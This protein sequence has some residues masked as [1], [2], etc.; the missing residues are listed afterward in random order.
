MYMG[1]EAWSA[2]RLV[3][4]RG[5]RVNAVREVIWKKCLIS[6]SQVEYAL[7]AWIGDYTDF[8]TSIHHAMNVGKL[9]RPDQPLMPNYQWIPIGYHGRSSSIMVSGHDIIRPR[10]QL[11]ALNDIAPKLGASQK[12]D[13]EL[14]LG[15]YIGVGNELGK[16]VAIDD[17]TQHVFGLCVLNDWSAR[18]IQAWEYQPLGPFLSKNFASSVS[19]WIVTIEALQPYM[20]DWQRPADH[21]QPLAYLDSDLHRATG[22][23]NIG[24]DVWLQTESMR[25]LGQWHHVSHSNYAD[26]YWTLAQ[27]VAHH[28]INGCNL[29]TGDLLG[30]GTQSG[31][32]LSQAGALIELTANGQQPLHLLNGEK[33]GFLS[34]GDSVKMTASCEREG[35][36][37]IGFGEVVG[38]ILPAVE[39]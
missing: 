22:A 18:D 16:S 24:L 30:T 7:P 2:L 33:R 13:Y 26:A 36:A 31:A 29:Q 35:F 27:M 5:L 15:A 39:C 6:Q 14:E 38:T 17:W 19:P 9:F 23:L 32:D 11:K 28:S 20:Q 4:S 21:P 12:L 10:S 25:A 8:Y 34:D 3:L 1:S 37:R